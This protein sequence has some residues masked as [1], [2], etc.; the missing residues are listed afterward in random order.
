MPATRPGGPGATLT[1]PGLSL[2]LTPSP[3]APAARPGPPQVTDPPWTVLRELGR[4]AGSVVHLAVRGDREYA[5]KRRRTDLPGADPAGPAGP[6]EDE[7]A[8]RREAALLASVHHPGLPR[9]HAVTEVEGRLGVVVDAH[10]GTTLADLLAPAPAGPAGHPGGARTATLPVVTTLR[11]VVDVCD[12]LHALHR[13]G[14][15]HGDVEPSNVLVT[16]AGR[17]V[18]VDPDLARPRTAAA[19]PHRSPEQTGAV[20][21]PVDHRSD[22]YS[23]GAVLL[24]CL[25]GR[26]PGGPDAAPGPLGPGVPPALGPLL[27]RLLAPEARDRPADATAVA[28]ELARLAADT[29]PDIALGR[30]RWHAPADAP[31]LERSR[32]TAALEAAW[33]SARAGSGGVVVVR[34][35]AGSGRSVLVEAL[36]RKAS[37]QGATTV[38][39]DTTT[40]P[41]APLSALRRAVPAGGLNPAGPAP[42]DPGGPGAEDPRPGALAE[43]LLQHAARTGPL[44]VVLDDTEHADASTLA[45]LRWLAAECADLPLLVVLVDRARTPGTP[46]APGEPGDVEDG[47]PGP[48]AVVLEVPPLSDAAARAVVRRRLPGAVVTDPVAAALVSRAAGNPGALLALLTT[49][50]DQGGL[51]P[52]WGRWRLEHDALEA[53]P[54]APRLLTALLRRLEELPAGQR[55]A[56]RL[57]AA[58]GRSVDDHLVLR[59]AV[60]GLDADAVHAGLAA[61]VAARLLRALPG[62]RHE[63]LHQQVVD[64]VLDGVGEAGRRALH[65]RLARVLRADTRTGADGADRDALFAC[66][67]QHLRAGDAMAPAD[68]VRACAAA[69]VEAARRFA[70][71]TAVTLLGQAVRT[72]DAAGLDLDPRLRRLLAACLAR[73]DRHAE[74]HAHLEHLLA[75]AADDALTRAVVLGEVALLHRHERTPHA[76]GRTTG[77]AARGLAQLRAARPVSA[78]GRWAAALAALLLLAGTVLHPGRRRDGRH[79]R[80][81]AR[82][83]RRAT[84]EGAHAVLLREA[85]AADLQAGRTAAAVPTA[86]AAWARAVRARRRDLAR[87]ARWSLRAALE[88]AR[89]G[90]ASVLPVRLPGGAGLVGEP[91]TAPDHR[92]GETEP[93]V[94]A[95][96]RL[97]AGLRRLWSGGTWRAVADVLEADGQWLDLPL[98]VLGTC[99]VA[100]ERLAAGHV[101]TA[102]AWHA[103]AARRVPAG[104]PAPV[105][106][107]LL[108]AALLSARGRPGEA[109]DVLDAVRLR[110]ERGTGDDPGGT[111]PLSGLQLQLATTRWLL[112]Q[113]DVGERFDEAAARAERLVRSTPLP[114]APEVRWTRVL[115]LQGRVA[116]LRAAVQAGDRAGAR[117]R[118]RQ[119]A[120]ALRGLRRGR[121][122]AVQ[123]AHVEVVRAAALFRLGRRGPASRL[124]GS[125]EAR[126]RHLDAPLVDHLVLRLRAEVAEAAGAQPDAD[127]LR[128]LATALAEKHGW[129]TLARRGRPEAVAGPAAGTARGPW[130]P[131]PGRRRRLLSAMRDVGHAAQVLDPQDVVRLALDQACEVLGADRAVL[132]VLDGRDELTVLAGRTRSGTDLSPA[133]PVDPAAARAARTG[134]PVVRGGLEPVPARVPAHGASDGVGGADGADGARSV[135]AVPLLV[136]GRRTG[137]LSAISTLTPGA[138][139]RGDVE[140]LQLIAGQVAAALETARAARLEIEVHG[141]QRERDLAEAVRR[142]TEEVSGSLELPTVRRRLLRSAV[143]ELGARRGALVPVRTGAG[144]DGG[145]TAPV[146]AL[147]T[148]ADGPVREVAW[149]RDWRAEPDCARLLESA[150]ATRGTT[151]GTTGGGTALPPRLAGLLDLAPGP[152]GATPAAGATGSDGAHGTDGGSWLVVPLKDRTG[153]VAEVL[154]LSGDADGPA[155]RAHVAEA[156]AAPAAIGLE[157]AR[158]FARVEHLARTD[159]LTGVATRG[160]L[161]RVG[162]QRLRADPEGPAAAVM[163]DVD[164]FKSVNDT[165]GHAAGDEVLAAVARR[166]Q[167]QTRGSDVLGRYG[168]EEFA[169]V[170]TGPGA[171]AEPFDP[172]EVAERLRAAVRSSPVPVRGARLR[173]TVSVGVALRRDGEHLPD[174]LARADAALYRAKA[175]GRDVVVAAP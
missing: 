105:E 143:T 44:L 96:V 7:R 18:L 10:D 159:S 8:L 14:L 30:R 101:G 114:G 12:A 138:F 19:P 137:V 15:V 55:D 5:V 139:G 172:L 20:R 100:G 70:P 67:H 163:V 24:Q 88:Q 95:S 64:A 68:V 21:G 123:D 158:L 108:R 98:Y 132:A 73:Q 50:L 33:D 116:Q 77:A 16:A 150:G 91:L 156:L 151:G 45:V 102:A 41:G 118:E 142:V 162:E 115:V 109:G 86:L 167:E 110:L 59:A 76:P 135:V 126:A 31:L 42:A 124:L 6:A 63:F 39:L 140:L 161:L 93:T 141:A 74:A 54:V 129:V 121:G 58:C 112:E 157:N 92:P 49:L 127:R 84:V 99:A 106:L 148:A 4:G 32:Q 145:P 22:L 51:V 174:V 80:D 35:A 53:V 131:A 26:T 146:P 36:R 52:E 149:G 27:R 97:A 85:A 170:L 66:A 136:R 13:S 57:A 173:V 17:A 3:A 87:D 75:P 165:H 48:G 144:P 23:V 81:S 171:G 175:A 133:E 90:R 56:L 160:H 9:V 113:A 79:R 168:G 1:A 117:E 34:G 134:R 65:A 72:A 111:D 47:L 147:V 164:H 94:L 38:V 169:L 71:E 2:V 119:V 152:G 103:R 60:P 62:G 107:E 40:S 37:A 28:D 153:L 25:T 43:E 11:L 78:P 125:A 29:A 46:A 69:G 154:V 166:L 122:S 128:W 61:G 130:T 120:D 83:V 104:A 82:E 155:S 89:T